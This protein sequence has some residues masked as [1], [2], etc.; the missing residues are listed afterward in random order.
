MVPLRTV[1]DQHTGS[2]VAIYK[3]LINSLPLLIP[4]APRR[5]SAMS[6]TSSPTSPGDIQF[7][8][9]MAPTR[10]ERRRGRLSFRAQAREIWMQRQ[11][12]WWYSAIA[13][14]VAGGVSIGFEK[15]S[16]GMVIAQQM[17]V[18]CVKQ[19]SCI[20]LKLIYIIPSGLQGTYN[21]LS[22]THNIKVPNGDVLVFSLW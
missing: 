9:H 10:S 11:T 4:P 3:L 15:R 19:S 16:R 12:R 2:F 18:R 7:P 6:P 22:T 14:A 21:A 17:F 1:T 20:Y 5:R 13:G 8:V